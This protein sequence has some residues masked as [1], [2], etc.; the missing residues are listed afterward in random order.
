[1][2]YNKWCT[3]SYHGQGADLYEQLVC[4]GTPARSCGNG[5]PDGAVMHPTRR[6]C[7]NVLSDRLRRCCRALMPQLQPHLAG[8]TTEWGPR[9]AAR[10]RQLQASSC[11]DGIRLPDGSLAPAC[12]Q[13]ADDISIHT[14]TVAAAAVALAEAVLP[15]GAASN[16]LLSLPKCIG[17]LLGPSAALPPA[18]TEPS[19]GMAFVQ[20]GAYVRH[21]GILL[22]AGDQQ[23]A[24]TRCL[25]SAL[26]PS[27]CGS[28]LG[29]SLT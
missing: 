29:A 28:L 22:S 20:P 23:E 5:A 12:H 14:G 4:S 1:M 10:L 2:L 6:S 3:T 25:C 26:L 9:L 18:G 27:G 7:K 17:M 19:T 15:F 21:L 24:T 8:L 13:H 16:A 11:I